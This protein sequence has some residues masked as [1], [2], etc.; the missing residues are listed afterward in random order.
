MENTLC[1]RIEI[2]IHEIEHGNQM[3]FAIGRKR[4]WAYTVDYM[5]RGALIYGGRRGIADAIDF[6]N[7]NS[8]INYEIDDVLHELDLCERDSVRRL[9]NGVVLWVMYYCLFVERMD[10]AE[11]DRY[12]TSWK[13]LISGWIALKLAKRYERKNA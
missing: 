12:F 10:K 4:Y 13:M 9:G 2:V 8:G 3:F 7:K 5:F 11:N 6:A 1:N